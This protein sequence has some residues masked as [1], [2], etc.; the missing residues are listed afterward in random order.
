MLKLKNAALTLALCGALSAHAA[1]PIK[2]GVALDISGPFATIGA[3]I[4]DGFNL[5]IEQLGGKLGG[6]PAEFLQTDFAGNPEQANQLVNRYLERD[7]I[8]FFTGPVASNAA[9]AVGPALFAARVPYL[10][11]NP[12]PS[13]YAGKQCNPYFFSVSYQNDTY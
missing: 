13:Q 7:K 12:G 4:R 11:S 2:V 10:S 9:L 3:E 5:A 1:D 8:D 6:M